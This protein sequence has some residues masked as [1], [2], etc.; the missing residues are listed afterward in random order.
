MVSVE[1]IGLL[2]D[3]YKPIELNARTPAEVIGLMDAN[4]PGFRRDIISKRYSMVLYD[5]TENEDC[6]TVVDADRAALPMGDEMVIFVPEVKGEVSVAF[7][8]VVSQIVTYAGISTAAG[9]AVVAA[10]V[11]VAFVAAYAYALVSLADA[12][13][14]ETP[15]HDGGNPKIFDGAVNTASQGLP[16]PVCY[17]GPI[18]VG[19]QVIS[20][21]VKSDNTV[22]ISRENSFHIPRPV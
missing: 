17:G 4:F 13:S 19:S 15:E 12:L 20:T 2:R 16:V 8:W 22:A 21:V 3:K 10:V 11:A 1:C 5:G 7:G 9:V 14:P 18:R 6:A